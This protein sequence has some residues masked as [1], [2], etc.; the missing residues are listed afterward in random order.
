MIWKIRKTMEIGNLSESFFRLSSEDFFKHFHRDAFILASLCISGYITGKLRTWDE[1]E[2]YYR[3]YA[4]GK[5]HLWSEDRP[6][7]IWENEI[8][9]H[10]GKLQNR[11]HEIDMALCQ[12]SELINAPVPVEDFLCEAQ[13]LGLQ[14]FPPEIAVEVAYKLHL[15]CD[16]LPEISNLAMSPKKFMQYRGDYFFFDRW[17]PDIGHYFELLNYKKKLGWKRIDVRTDNC[18]IHPESHWIFMLPKKQ[19]SKID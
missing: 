17:I 6:N 1:L 8:E 11:K 7:G 4:D 16:D 18:D 2:Q 13:K 15:E 12:A 10:L 9:P 14:L 5:K 19:D 3:L